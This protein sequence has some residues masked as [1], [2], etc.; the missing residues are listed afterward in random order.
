MASTR[1]NAVMPQRTHQVILLILLPTSTDY[2]PIFFLATISSGPFG[3]FLMSKDMGGI[4]F[5][6][7]YSN[8]SVVHV[9]SLKV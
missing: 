7:I 2:Q 5:N 9:R 1:V 8:V 4:K 3:A 6:T